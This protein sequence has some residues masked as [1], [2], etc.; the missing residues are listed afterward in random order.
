MSSISRLRNT[1]L[2]GVTARSLPTT[3]FSVPTGGRPLAVRSQSSTKFQKP[4]T[5]FCPASACVF[6]RI[7]GLVRT[8]LDGEKMSSI[9]RNVNSR[10]RSWCADTPRTPVA[11]LNHHCCC[12]R[13]V[14]YMTLK[15]HCCHAGL[16]EA[17]VL[18]QRRDAGL[19]ALALARAARQVSCQA[20][21]SC[22]RPCARA[23][24]ACRATARGGR[25]SRSRPSPAPSARARTWRATAGSAASD[26]SP[27]PSATRD[28]RRRRLEGRKTAAPV[29]PRLGPTD[30]APAVPAR[31]RG[32]QAGSAGI[33]GGPS[34]CSA[35]GCRAG[36]R[37][38]RFGF[39]E[40]VQVSPV[41][42]DWHIDADQPAGNTESRVGT[43]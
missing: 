12:S 38:L 40:H 16:V 7:S 2:P 3:N 39:I 41:Q 5:R 23:A 15:G 19:D 27:R 32:L 37:D 25:A 31:R 26:P 6:A 28:L 20:R 35:A 18:R 22:A 13:N 34:R 21:R 11:A 1:T 17:L 43:C 9:C 14:W 10:M 29:R 36:T 4:R 42:A 24:A 8:K 30:R 33:A